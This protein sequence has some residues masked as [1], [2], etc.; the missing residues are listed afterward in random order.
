MDFLK[1]ELQAGV[2]CCVGAGHLT[3]SL[4]E[5]QVFFTFE[6]SLQPLWTLP[7][8]PPCPEVFIL[9]LLPPCSTS[10]E[11]LRSQ[12]PQPLTSETVSQTKP[13]LPPS[14]AML[15]GICDGD[16]GLY[17]VSGSLLSFLNLGLWGSS[18]YMA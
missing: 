13:S 12:Q 9:S 11:E 3:H 5:Q 7:F 16:S 8:W 14:P 6:P 4:Q 10:V 18:S 1:L 15:L 2:S 17:S